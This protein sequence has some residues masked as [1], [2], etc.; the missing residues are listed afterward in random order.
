[1]LEEFPDL[2]TEK[3]MFLRIEGMKQWQTDCRFEV[4]VDQYN[5]TI[6]EEI[7][8]AVYLSVLGSQKKMKTPQVVVSS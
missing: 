2:V 3:K 6:E 1:M 8:K 4:S 7:T 5:F